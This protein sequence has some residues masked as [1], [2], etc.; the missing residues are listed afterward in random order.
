MLFRSRYG[1]YYIADRGCGIV[2]KID[3]AGYIALFA[4][5]GTSMAVGIPATDAV[6]NDIVDVAV[7]DTGNVYLPDAANY[8]LLKVNVHTNIISSI[9]GTGVLGYSGMAA[10]QQPHRLIILPV[11][12]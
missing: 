4:G 1:N 12:L 11:Y 5:G 9:A 2:L 6:L 8:R 7:D 10:L 3:T